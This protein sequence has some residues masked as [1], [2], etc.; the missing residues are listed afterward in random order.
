MQATAAGADAGTPPGAGST[1]RA[2]LLLIAAVVA[3]AALSVWL[4]SADLDR[5]PMHTDEA[6]HA[7]KCLTLLERGEYVYDPHDYHGPTLYYLTLPVLWAAGVH[8]P[9]DA[10]E[11]MFRVVPVGVAAAGIMLLVLLRDALGFAGTLIAALCTAV[12]PA[13]SFYAGYYIQETLLVTF[14]L[15]ALGA[16]WRYCRG[17]NT[18]WMIACGAAAGLMHA[19]KETSLIVFGAAAAALLLTRASAPAAMLRSGRGRRALLLGATAAVLVSVALHT[20]FGRNPRGLPDAGV[21]VVGYVQRAFRGSVAADE[22][23]AAPH[24]HPMGFYIERHFLPRSGDS[25]AGAQLPL[26]LFAALAAWFAFAPRRTT[27]GAGRAKRIDHEAEARFAPTAVHAADGADLRF[28][29]FLVLFTL[30]P[31]LAYSVLPY[32]TP[33]SFLGVVHLTSLLAGCGAGAMIERLRARPLAVAAALVLLT[34]CAGRLGMISREAA[35]EP[36][37]GVAGRFIYGQ[38]VDGGRRLGEFVERLAA[39]DPARAGAAGL[40]HRR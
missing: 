40:C 23:A 38:S 17:G 18:G 5:R 30:L 13:L 20:N 27:P 1:R 4:R 29:R 7:D 9:A 31:A 6:I 12:L 28:V 25:L 36:L 10:A 33:W 15:A 8:E 16:G 19:T 35:A 37:R 3:A 2:E 14:T 39:V 21:A 24:R 34:A 22:A 11:W 26:L 32:K